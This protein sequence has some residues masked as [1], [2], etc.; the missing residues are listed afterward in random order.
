MLGQGEAVKKVAAAMLLCVL[1]VGV[2]LAAVTHQKQHPR[3]EHAGQKRNAKRSHREIRA[4]NRSIRKIHK[5]MGKQ[6]KTQA[7]HESAASGIPSQ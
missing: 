3:V 1:G 7:H 4:E 2:P 5:S 6:A